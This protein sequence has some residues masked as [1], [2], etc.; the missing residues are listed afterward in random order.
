[1]KLRSGG[2]A[3]YRSGRV[4]ISLGSLFVSLSAL[5]CGESEQRSLPPEVESAIGT[6][7]DEIAAER[8]KNLQRSL[9]SL[10]ARRLLEESPTFK[11]LRTKLVW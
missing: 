3:V 7:N 2:N 4:G 8:Y 9:G 10:A 5:L 11:T 1:M 6:I